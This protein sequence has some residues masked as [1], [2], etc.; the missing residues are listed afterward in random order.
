M[1][2]LIQQTIVITVSE[3]VKDAEAD[4]VLLGH[5]TI[6]NIE[7]VVQQLAQSNATGTVLVEVQ[8]A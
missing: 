7:E 8:Q 5:D 2:K 6:A 4:H 3:M 1:A